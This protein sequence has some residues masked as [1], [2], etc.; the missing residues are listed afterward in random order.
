MGHA[1]VM[2]PGMAL[3]MDLASDMGQAGGATTHTV[4]DL[5]VAGGTAMRTVV[6]E[7]LPRSGLLR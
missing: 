3:D 4:S 1:H 2:P 5:D 6:R 7:A